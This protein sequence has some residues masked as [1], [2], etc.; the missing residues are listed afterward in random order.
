MK[1]EIGGTNEYN[2]FIKNNKLLKFLILQYF[3]MCL[4][5]ISSVNFTNKFYNNHFGKC[6][7]NNI[8]IV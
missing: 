8:I 7:N 4:R 2:I 5:N 3:I 6:T 1:I